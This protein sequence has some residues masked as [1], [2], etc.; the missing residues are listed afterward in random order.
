M[1]I[2]LVEDDPQL[3]RA[4]QL[5]LDQLGYAVD[6]VQSAEDA[7]ISI[8]LHQ[9]QCLLLD[10]GLPRQDGMSLLKKLRAAGFEQSILILTARDQIPDRIMG[11]DSG[12]DDF[13][14]KPYDLD[15]LAARIRSVRRR[16][17]GRSREILTHRGVEIDT[18]ARQVKL[19]GESINLTTREFNILQILF[20][21]LGQ[22]ITKDQLEQALYSWGDEIE[23]NTIQVHIHHLRKKLGKELIRTL[24]AVGYVIDKE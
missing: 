3:G 4:T 5:G 11:L 13:I 14:V 23:S 18:A 1:R 7:E 6:W 21:H 22:I 24:H 8:K 15:E 16:L 2:L 20:E 12:A 17:V 19:H 10:L 9:Y